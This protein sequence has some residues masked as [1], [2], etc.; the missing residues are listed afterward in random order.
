MPSE[1]TRFG[2]PTALELSPIIV[3]LLTALPGLLFASSIF[4]ICGLG[5]WQIGLIATLRGT[6]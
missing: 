3:R 1:L 2:T 4:L 6:D 5:F